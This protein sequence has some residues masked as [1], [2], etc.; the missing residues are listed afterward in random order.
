MRLALLHT[1]PLAYDLFRR[2][3]GD[4]DCFH[5]IDEHLF[6]MIRADGSAPAI[7][8]R[9][10]GLMAAAAAGG[11]GTLLCTCSSTSPC[12]DRASPPEGLAVMK[13]D[14]PACRAVASRGGR[15][16]IV[17]SIETTVDSTMRRIHRFA[18]E[19]G[20]HVALSGILAKGAFE[21][22]SAGDA[23][24]HDA[25]VLEAI[26]GADQTMDRLFLAQASLARV[27]DEARAATGLDVVTTPG[28]CLTALR[29]AGLIR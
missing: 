29:E 10:A 18:G 11:A 27:A 26:A 20:T 6:N 21:A 4:A 8:E 22:L 23:E 15:V 7:P 13:I 1:T 24:R 3:L 14:D 16:G 28:A 9:I 2:E 12:F 5:L 17:C 25:L 19:L